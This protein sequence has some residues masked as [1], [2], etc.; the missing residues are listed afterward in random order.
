M[1]FSTLPETDFFGRSDELAGLSR[2]ADE[3][4]KGR[5][6]SAVLFGAP[7]M[8]KTE[9]LKQFFNQLFWRQDRVVPFYYA[10]NPALLSCAAFSQDYLARYL[11]QRLA[12]DR[13]EQSL[14]YLDGIPLDGVSALVEERG[15][16]WARE[17][18]DRYQQASADPLGAL[19]VALS[20]P[21]R[22]ALATGV[23]AAVLIDDFHLLSGLR[24]GDHQ[25]DAGLASLFAEPMSFG[26]T[27][28]IITGNEAELREL[29]VAR[30]LERI[31]LQPLGSDEAKAKSLALLQAYEVE[32]TVPPPLLLQQL[33]G[34][35]FYLSC[36]LR[37]VSTNNKP[38][39]QSYWKA[40][41][42]EVREGNIALYWSSVLKR[43]FPAFG[44]RRAAL[45]I[46]A[47]VRD[48]NGP[49]SIPLLSKALGLSEDKTSTAI[50]ALHL[51]GM[52]RGEFGV[53]RATSDRVLLDVLDGLH[54][55]EVLGRSAQELERELLE[56]A[57][58]REEGTV[59]FS[60]TLPM[61][62]EAELVAAQC[63]DQI[64]KNLNVDQEAIGQLQIAVIEACINAME[65][66]KG[67]DSNVYLAVAVDAERAE[68]SIESAGREFIM[69]ETGEPFEGKKNG[70]TPGRGWGIKLMKRFVDEVRFERTE[71]G[72]RTVLV[73]HLAKTAGVRKENVEDRE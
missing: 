8:G 59:R 68:V 61:V 21:H 5:A 51:A 38:D 31:M 37:A 58:P 41:A 71:R 22:S 6:Q 64:G 28:H 42:G 50:S 43:F 2:R 19:R 39:E 53:F 35:P 36:L 12:F 11:C 67:D 48:T 4:V 13:K 15:A 52:V 10:V 20:A 47:K 17:L 25:P 29:P 63:L 40:Y 56:R 26:R 30:G 65:H 3:A 44:D 33:G 14:F 46:A 70:K 16:A 34:N 18:L 54:S 32:G 62:K 60:M 73:K 9:L 66:G 57:L 69:Q 1:S 7:G 49:L 27:P 55:R 72:T 45:A 24:C 23:P